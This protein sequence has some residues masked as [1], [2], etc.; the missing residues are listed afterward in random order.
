MGQTYQF[1]PVIPPLITEEKTG[2]IVELVKAMAVNMMTA[3]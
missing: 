2:A 1:P 3:K